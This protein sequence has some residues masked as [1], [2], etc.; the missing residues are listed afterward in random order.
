MG[1]AGLRCLSGRLA[2]APPLLVRRSLSRVPSTINPA[3]TGQ[4]LTR[5]MAVYSSDTS[6]FPVKD[7]PVFTNSPHSSRLTKLSAGKKSTLLIIPGAV[8]PLRRKQENSD[9]K[10]GDKGK[11][12]RDKQESLVCYYVHKEITM[13]EHDTCSILYCTLQDL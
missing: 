3:R 11:G 4:I 2:P 8:K 10:K 6:V 7:S 1:L 12:M 13:P 5:Q 9:D